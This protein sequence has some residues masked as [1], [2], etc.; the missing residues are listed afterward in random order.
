VLAPVPV[1]PDAK[2]PPDEAAQRAAFA[3]DLLAAAGGEAN[4]APKA[5]QKVTIDGKDHEWRLV[6]SESDTVSFASGGSVPSFVVGYAWAEV[7]MPR[8][9]AGVLGLGS[10]D[11]V[12]AWINGREVHA[13]W[14]GRPVEPDADVVPVRFDAGLNR[15]LLK[16]QNVAGDWGFTCRR[17]GGMALQ[18][19]LVTAAGRGDTAAIEKVLEGGARISGADGRGLT[20]LQSARL[21]GRKKA[22]DL[23]LAKGAD[24][25]AKAPAVDAVVDRTFKAI[26]K[27]GYPGAA[28][29]VSRDGRI[30][31]RR[32]YGAACLENHVAAIPETRYRI[33]SI[34]KQFTAAA[35][36][37]L[38]E[39]GKL[40]VEDSL[41]KFLP[42]FPRGG[43]VTV[44]H[45]LTHS[46]GIHSY[47]NKPDFLAQ[48][49]VGTTP[50]EL[51]RSFRD[52]PFDFDPGLRFLYNNSGYFL[53]G[54]IVEKVSGLPYAEYLRRTF[55]EPLGMRSTGVH[56]AREVIE[57]EAC[58][59]TWEDGRVRK[60]LNWDMSR[61]GGAGAL[62][63]TV[64]DLN[65]WNEALFAGK[66]LSEASLKAATTPAPTAEDPG[67]K[68]EGYGYGLG[69]GRL[70]GL[71]TISHG[72]GLHGFHSNLLRIPDQR[73]NVVVLVNSAPNVPGLSANTL[74]SEIAEL[75]LGESMAERSEPVADASVSPSS[76]DDYVG[77]YDYGG[78]V[79]TVTREGDRLFA[80]L[81]GQPKFE[82][83][84][85]A[86]D[87]FFWKVVE[88]EVTFVKD[89]KGKVV[90][91]RHRQGG[92][93]ITAPRFEPPA[94]AK[95]DPRLYDDYVG[96]YD[97]GQGRAIMA[98]TREGDR[99]FAQLTGQPRFEIFPKAEAEFFWKVVPAEISFVRDAAGKVTKAVHRQGGQTID[100]PRVE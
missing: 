24:A 72:G 43:E 60:A 50:Q 46:S 65:R 53:L 38:Q 63:S 27:D 59:Y 47:T 14:I 81:T 62:Y 82:I 41:S 77:S 97:Y 31:F 85:R 57:A 21:H 39:E 68:E 69:I 37:R 2:E 48:V 8:A 100:A 35:V 80:Q 87:V 36:L 52:D 34:T 49:T 20:A 13:N 30:L 1:S 78:A 18:D 32:S 26:V 76:Y 64:D 17:L 66:V 84:P 12:K 28:V 19:R 42:D 73:F 45:L 92:Q 22:A 16:V 95:V 67:P 51:I 56:D 29:L 71:R 55:F 98:I 91:A 96:K 40:R 75:Y 74:S 4:A 10:D 15:I 70:R 79:L 90:R 11:G 44:H 94:V 99:L 6:D 61:A 33:G 83:F 25:S 89:E 3:R 93:T 9:E 54:H 58:G 23:L 7:E 86:K 5:G 88:A